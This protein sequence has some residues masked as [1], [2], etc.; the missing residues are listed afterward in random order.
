[1]LGRKSSVLGFKEKSQITGWMVHPKH[2]AKAKGFSCCRISARISEFERFSVSHETQHWELE[3]RASY[4]LRCIHTIAPVKS[5]EAG[6][7]MMMNQ[8]SN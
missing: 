3:F 5:A 1:M 8:N 4:F 7:T 6:S 2:I